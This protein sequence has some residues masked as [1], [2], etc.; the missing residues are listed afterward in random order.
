VFAYGQT[1]SG[2]TYTMMGS[3][4]DDPDNKGIIPR[5][6]EQIFESIQQAPINMEFTVK[7]AYMEIYMERV[8]D[9]L[10]RK[11]FATNH[12]LLTNVSLQIATND[13][14]P[15]HE[16]KVK[17]VYVKG[18][19]EVYVADTKEVYDV[20]RIGGDNRVVASTSM[21]FSLLNNSAY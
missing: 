2:K 12:A 21:Y 17:G 4:I 16:D 13:N 3:N 10:V 19:K 7:V 14:L 15:I 9:L 5:I 1:G 6:I 20:M 8:K 11:S 18:I